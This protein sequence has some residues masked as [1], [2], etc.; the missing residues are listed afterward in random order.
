MAPGARSKFVVPMFE[1]KFFR[2]QMYYIEENTCD[3]V[4]RNTRLDGTRGKKQVCR[5]HVRT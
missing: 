5:P 2:K 1:P 4:V 3:I